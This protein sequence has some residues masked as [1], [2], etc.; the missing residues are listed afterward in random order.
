[1]Q[2][3]TRHDGPRASRPASRSAARTAPSATFTEGRAKVLLA[4][5]L[6][7]ALAF[8]VRLLQL[9]VV[10]AS[11]NASNAADSRTVSITLAPKRGTIYDRN[12]N[13]LATS[14]DAKTVYCNPHD[15][16]DAS[17]E[18]EQ[19]ASV[20]GGKASEWKE[21]LTQDTTFVYLEKQV[22]MERAEQ[23]MDLGLDGVYFLDDSKRVYPYGEV[24]G[25][26]IGLI[27]VDGNGLT[28]LELYYDDVLS[29]EAGTLT[30]QYYGNDGA[31]IP[32]SVTEDKPAVDGE[33]IVISLDIG[34][35]Q[36]LEER[37]AQT[38]KD[39]EGKGGNSIVYDG[40]T[41]EIY[42]CASLPYLDPSDREHIEDGS[43]ELKSIT[44]AFEPG[45]IFK[46]VTF[47]AIMEAGLYSPDDTIFCPAY[48]PADEYF[49]SDAHDRGD[50]TMTVR[51]ILDKSSNVGTSLAAAQLGFRPL[52]EKILAY[53]LNEATGV[54]YPGEAS[55]YLANV[56]DWS[57]IQAYNVSFGQG[58]SVTP[59][60]ITRFYG[61][62]V[63]DGVE[64]TPHFLM[65]RLNSDDQPEWTTE[66]VIENKDAIATMTDMLTTVVEDGTGKDAAIEG[67]TVAGKTGTAEYAS[68]DGG[69]VEGCYNISF[70]GFLP[71]SNSQ[72]VCFVGATEVPGDRST[73]A[74]FSDIMAFATER[75]RIVAE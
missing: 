67:Y 57:T 33:D 59:L 49:V 35:Q 55:G 44:A 9:T 45:S 1:M 65:Q 62:L 71:N 22:E 52:Y 56:D 14:V 39:L 3:R 19:I 21:L 8:A 18:A 43:T 29:G 69:Y 10:D 68:E 47:T 13:V 42:A 41:G 37:L 38:A 7:L 73:T 26:V 36:Y 64:C 54:D 5:F 20:L 61:A 6:V 27:D 40:G 58:V 31:T 70:V 11:E 15:V 4:V 16:S 34:M 46:A 60:Q 63:N 30:A 51:D 23:L 25:Q 74:A 28:G 24:G 12:G 75:Y 2:R 48:L 66:Q 32:G 17:W 72:L 50:E 53:N